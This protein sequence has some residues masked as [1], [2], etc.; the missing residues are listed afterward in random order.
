MGPV[1]AADDRVSPE[2]HAGSAGEPLEPADID[3]LIEAAMTE[4]DVAGATVAYVEGDELVYAEGYGY[5]DYETGDAVDP[6]ETAFMIGSV[7]KLLVWTAVM[8]GVEDGTL[9][10]DEPVGTYLDAYEFEGDDE[11]TLA[12][13]ATHAG[14]YDDRFKGL[15][16]QDHGEIDDWE[17][18]LESE[19]PPQIWEPGETISYSNH[20]TA[21]A[22]LV[23]QEAY[24]E[25]FESHIENEI[26]D[27]LGM[28]SATFVQ[29]VPED[30]TL[31]EGHVPVDD[32]FETR[33]PA[34]LGIPPAGSVSATAPDMGTFALA[35]L[36]EGAVE[37]DGEDVQLLEAES[38]EE[39]F[40]QQATNHPGVHGVGY[41][42]MLSEYRGEQLV[43]HTGGTEHFHTAFVLFPEHDAGLFVS[44]NTMAP[45]D[46]VLD[47]FIDERFAPAESS[48]EP[49][50]TT[51]D[52]ADE[53]A[54]EYRMT[55]FQTTHEKFLGLAQGTVTVSVTDDGV[56]ELT[57]PT[58]AET[59]WVEVEPG[60][61]EPKTDDDASVGQTSMAIEDGYLYMNAPAAPFERL[62]WYET[63]N[64]QVG[65]AGAVILTLLSTI[66]VWPI[67]AYRHRGWGAMGGY[68]NRPRL[69]ILG[70]V[71]LLAAFI[72]GVV[73][74]PPFE[75]ASWVY[76]FSLWQRVTFGLLTVLAVG[77]AVAATVVGL[78]W[79]RVYVA[80]DLEAGSTNRYGLIYLTILVAALAI[81]LW[82]AW[83]WNLFSAAL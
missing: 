42:Y 10:L 8:Q 21:L 76:G 71:G 69:A 2:T 58:G 29:P 74:N 67:N 78:E 51:A 48:L 7:S 31:S 19:M 45:F 16:V 80:R 75:M 4:H 72:G 46:D 37:H 64:F 9:D 60:V 68:L 5:A 3:T 50:P 25:P 33:D 40:E 59:R 6:N 18:K 35:K 32:G 12:H 15:F 57:M 26:F 63:A 1:A 11:V 27:P 34:I 56:L 17:G 70:C 24:G 66:V 36:Q 30:R 79:Q 43:M 49:N 54:G 61:F 55:T 22:G 20:G 14:G 77:T 82:Q 47:G 83:Y 28:D 53:Y 73:L 44:F 52:R 39:L 62:S 38:V 41:G 65:L 81:L 13:L 23:V